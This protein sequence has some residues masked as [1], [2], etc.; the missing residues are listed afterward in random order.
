M[1][2]GAVVDLA[3]NLWAWDKAAD[4]MAWADGLFADLKACGITEVWCPTSSNLPLFLS[5]AASHG[6]TVVSMVPMCY[7]TDA[8]KVVDGG[9]TA[10]HWLTASGYD[11]ITP[12]MGVWWDDDGRDDADINLA[13]HRS[14][15]AANVN[16]NLYM[17]P[18]SRF[19]QQLLPDSGVAAAL[20]KPYP[21]YIVP[22]MYPW[23]VAG[24]MTDGLV[25]FLSDLQT[26]DKFNA[27]GIH[28]GIFMQ[29]HRTASLEYPQPKRTRL[30]LDLLD[31]VGFDGP[32]VFFTALQYDQAGA[33]PDVALYDGAKI[34]AG[35]WAFGRSH[36]LNE[37]AAW[38]AERGM[39]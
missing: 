33:K 19:M 13:K 14:L 6:M 12:L 39:I 32:L 10:R 18:P 31:A 36:V 9:W 5:F 22:Q 34:L 7:K 11:D 28:T 15:V 38:A 20:K 24:S 8:S 26:L 35:D 2:L 25:S 1:L 30:L 16:L 21:D 23:T 17:S 27:H 3:G 4:R 29:G 37:I